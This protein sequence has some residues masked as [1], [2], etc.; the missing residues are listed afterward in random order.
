M[1]RMHH[2]L[3]KKRRREWSI[4][5]RHLNPLPDVLLLPMY[6]RGEGT[7]SQAFTDSATPNGTTSITTYIDGNNLYFFNIVHGAFPASGPKA[8]V[9]LPGGS[10]PKYLDFLCDV[11]NGYYHNWQVYAAEIRIRVAIVDESGVEKPIRQFPFRAILRAIKTLVVLPNQNR[12]PLWYELT[13]PQ[14]REEL[15]D[16]TQY[17]ELWAPTLENAAK[18]AEFHMYRTSKEVFGF[19]DATY[20]ANAF[21]GQDDVTSPNNLWSYELTVTPFAFGAIQLPTQYADGMS[22]RYE[23][24]MKW[25]CRFWADRDDTFAD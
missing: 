6:F 4:R 1:Y 25:L 12:D 24:E 16:N 8:D 20:D 10:T 5:V 3:R 23:V 2:G 19:P 13:V 18:P 17:K 21:G 22:L 9:F 11:T 15:L 14:Q 7:G